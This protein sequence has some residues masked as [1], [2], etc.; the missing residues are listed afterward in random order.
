VI[1][2]TVG[3]CIYLGLA[4][5]HPALT[6]IAIATFIMTAVSFFTAGN[7]TVLTFLPLL[8]RIR[9]EEAL[10]REHFG[11]ER[12]DYCAHTPR[13]IPGIY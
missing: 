5:F 1:L 3:V 10:L 4:F 7:I 9:A 6:V 11:A 13:L 2:N 12:G 8:L